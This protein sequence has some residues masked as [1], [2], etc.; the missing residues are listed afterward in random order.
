M[1]DDAVAKRGTDDDV[2]HLG[3]SQR[4]LGAAQLNDDVSDLAFV[5]QH[6][7]ATH[8]ERLGVPF[9]ITATGTQVG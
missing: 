2:R 9:K 6:A 8:H 1:R 7:F 3:N 4:S 5:P